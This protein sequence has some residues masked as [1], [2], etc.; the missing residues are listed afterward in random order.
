MYRNMNLQFGK[1]YTP[2]K[3]HISTHA[4]SREKER[5]RRDTCVCIYVDVRYTG[6]ISESIAFRARGRI[7][8]SEVLGRLSK[9]GIV[10]LNGR[11]PSNANCWLGI[12]GCVHTTRVRILEA[13]NVVTRLRLESTE[14]TDSRYT[15]K[16]C[17]VRLRYTD[18]VF[19]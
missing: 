9:G 6:V 4:S 18:I 16:K 19:F 5:G 3:S 13:R 1:K 17:Y 15:S 8:T 14:V 10:P 12:S 11:L 7:A 2:S